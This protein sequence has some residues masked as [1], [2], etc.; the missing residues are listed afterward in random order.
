[1]KKDSNRLI[2]HKIVPQ[3]HEKQDQLP[4]TSTSLEI[5]TVWVEIRNLKL[6][7]HKN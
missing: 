1:M 7:S 6:S 3:E 2:L 4:F 5:T